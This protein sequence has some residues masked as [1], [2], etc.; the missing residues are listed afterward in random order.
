MTVSYFPLGLALG[1]AFCNRE[2]QRRRLKYNIERGTTSLLMSPRRFGK[3][4]LVL[5]TLSELGC[6]YAYMDLFPKLNEGDIEQAILAG[7]GKILSQLESAPKRALRLVNELLSGMH[8]KVVIGNNKVNIEIER[9]SKRSIEQVVTVL[10]KLDELAKQHEQKVVLFLDEFQ[11][12]SEVC[13]NISLEGALRHVAQQATYLVFVFSGSNRHLLQSMFDDSKR[14]FYNLCDR[15]LLGRIAADDYFPFIQKA[16]VNRWGKSLDSC[17]ISELLELVERHPYYV[18]VIGSRLWLSNSLPTSQEIQVCWKN[19]QE[20]EKTRVKIELDLL[21]ANQKKLLIA[22]ARFGDEL[23]PMSTSFVKCSGVPLASIR[24]S[25][26][27]LE[28]KD[29][30][31][32]G[33]HNHYH[34]VDPLIKNVIS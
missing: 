15:I 12:I 5:Q 27:V 3:T 25:L 29:Y 1:E 11:R 32:P 7:A 4:S 9:Q 14:P 16:A 23:T 21:S 13:S 28:A 24:Q 8:A 6:P 18:N 20:E 34:L 30:V 2:E 31:E 22:I 17:I 10:T 33:S 19:Y 26:T